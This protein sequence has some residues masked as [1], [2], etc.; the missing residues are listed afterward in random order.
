MSD[1]VFAEKAKCPGEPEL[2]EALGRSKNYWDELLIKLKA[3]FGEATPEWKFFSP[4]YGWSL[5]V[6]RKKRTI[7]WMIPHSKSFGAG[8]ALGEKAVAEALKSKL[9]DALKT[10]IKYAKKYAEGRPARVEVKLKK[11][12]ELV[13][14]LAKIKISN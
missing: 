3:E 11:D 12:V 13:M 6:S 8:F 1:V 9:P 2:A 4:K 5:K 7:V 14:M 10:E